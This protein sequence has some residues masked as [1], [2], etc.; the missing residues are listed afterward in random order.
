MADALEILIAERDRLNRAIEILQG[1]TEAPRRGRKPGRPPGSANKKKARKARKAMS[2]A[3]K[4]A[5]SE[6]MKKYWAARRKAKGKT[7]G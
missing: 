6:R 3:A 7:K 4:K 2:P 1:E 5:V